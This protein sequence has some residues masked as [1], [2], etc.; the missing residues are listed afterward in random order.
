[1][2]SRAARFARLGPSNCGADARRVFLMIGAR[3]PTR[4][5][6][7]LDRPPASGRRRFL[8]RELSMRRKHFRGWWALV[9]VVLALPGCTRD[10]GKT[11]KGPDGKGKGGDGGLQVA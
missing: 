11:S 1:M 10:G 5:A 9:F 7:R 3:L 8:S 6:R 4:P 2:I